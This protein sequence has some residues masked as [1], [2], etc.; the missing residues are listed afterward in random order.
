MDP[1]IWE[2]PYTFNPDR[3][4]P[5]EVAKRHP[6][7]WIPFSAGPR[8]CIGK[9]SKACICCLSKCSFRNEVCDGIHE[10]N[11]FNGSATIQSL[12]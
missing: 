8:N 11:A 7:S 12:L 10:S 3:F 9:L 2:D 4:V 6:Y 5:E 1:K